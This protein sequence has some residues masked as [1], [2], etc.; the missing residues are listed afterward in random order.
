[1]K[2]LV[3]FFVLSFSAAAFAASGSFAPNSLTAE[4]RDNPVGID[5]PRPRLS[6]KLPTGCVRQTAYEIEADGWKSGRVESPESVNVVWQ[7]DELKTSQRVRWRVRVWNEKGTAT[8]WS[9]FASFTM[10]VMKPSDWKAKWIGPA[11][12]TQA[13]EDF[14][15]A[16]WITAAAD[17]KGVVT[18]EYTFH[19]WDNGRPRPLNRNDCADF[20]FAAFYECEIDVNGKQFHRPY[21][22]IHDWRY[23]YFRNMTDWLVKGENRIVVRVKGE[24]TKTPPAFIA[25][26]ALPDGRVLV[27]GRDWKA[28][29]NAVHTLG[30]MRETEFGREMKLRWETVSPA[31]A[32]RFTVREGLMRAVLHVTGVGYYE[33][34]L[35]GC[36]IGDKVLD[37]SPSDF[38]KRVLYS[39]YELGSSLHPGEHELKLLVGHG[40]Y[41]VRSIAVWN[42]NIAPWRDF[43]RTIAQLELEYRDG[44]RERVLTDASWDQVKSPVGYDC[45]RE[46]EVVGGGKM[47]PAG[48]KARE[49]KG[50]GGRLVAE[51]Q[52]G[53]KIVRRL[54]PV[55]TKRLDDGSYMLD[56]GE[57]LAG[58][59]RLPM[60]GQRAGDLVTIRYD[61]RVNEGMTPAQPSNRDGLHSVK[62]PVSGGVLPK[63]RRCID[64]FGRYPASHRVCPENAAFQCDRYFARGEDGEVYEPRF[65]WNGFRY[66]WIRGLAAEP[67]D[68]EA[69]MVQTDFAAAG[70]FRCSD[71]MFSTLME[72]TDRAYRCNFTDGY[73]TDCPHREK[74]G[75]A[76][77][78]WVASE[79][80]Q[81]AYENTA[82][83]EKWVRDLADTQLDDGNICC[84]APTSGWGF[85]WG[86]GPSWD[87]ALSV[88]PWN[89]W[90]YR[91]N[92]RFLD[93]IYPKLVRYN[94]YTATRADADG[95]VKH[96]LGDWISVDP[97]HMPN[98]ELT[99][100]CFRYQSLRIAAEMAKLQGRGDEAARFDAEARRVAE[101]INRR[102]YRGDG[103]YE[104]GHM[105]AQAFPLA[106]G[107]VP[108]GEVAAV[109][110]KLIDCAVKSDNHCDFGLLGAKFVLREFSNAGRT[111]LAFAMLVNPTWPSPMEWIRKGGTTL[112]ED[113]VD[114]S[115]RNH[116]MFGDFAGWAYRYLAGIGLKVREGSCTAI[117]IVEE[118]GLRRF[119][120][121]PQ[122]IAAL[123]WVEASVETP[124]GTIRSAWRREKGNVF[125][126]FTV[127]AGT[128]AELRLPNGPVKL[129][130]P[131]HHAF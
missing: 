123:D 87:A 108:A 103:V 75:W 89:L 90:C 81:Y 33:A 47:P 11:A 25:K 15:A 118:A 49:V 110:A 60:R 76:G 115:S 41:D 111:D 83:Y 46:G 40:W 1:M 2:T 84:I 64:V 105:T 130:A 96:G 34:R 116:I 73:P 74:N 48:L 101:A 109:R 122:P 52:P 131:G 38:S 5:T 28:G 30:R 117:P 8:D 127:P 19:I 100:S 61:E 17:E 91:G 119:V 104:N 24:G 128:Q 50:P 65:T 39:T 88:I 66:V 36:K 59:I 55:V 86:N 114:G 22:H 63:A 3:S 71:R 126:E 94:A 72:M 80:A 42:F 31:F 78:A 68:V 79:Y 14:G 32:K 21:G 35:D 54:K 120:L 43:P 56:F 26:L 7:G 16:E 98:A 129:L 13:D 121:E 93:E 107:I 4:Y 106:F 70:G 9:D 77:D 102:F 6:W 85:K 97:K 69:C 44:S 29:G 27:T 62:G 58:W 82:G 99:S 124:Y 112:W 12:E 53:A 113:W 45:L 57:N 18:L 23:P 37:P 125:Y 10:G 92:R 51:N 95:L 20:V 67:T